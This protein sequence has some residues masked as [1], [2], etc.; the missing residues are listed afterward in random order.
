M[1]EKCQ[2]VIAA[3]GLVMFMAGTFCGLCAYHGFLEY[4]RTFRSWRSS[5]KAQLQDAEVS[6]G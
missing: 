5:R 6:R 3:M 2:T 1:T 4:R